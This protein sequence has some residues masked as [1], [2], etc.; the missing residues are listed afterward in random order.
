[1]V[2]Q[3]RLT[4]PGIYVNA[5]ITKTNTRPPLCLLS[6]VAMGQSEPGKWLLSSYILAARLG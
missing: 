6:A 3:M 5:P 4:S 1:M 2:S